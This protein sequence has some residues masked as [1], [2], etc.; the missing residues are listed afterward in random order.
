MATEAH[1]FIGIAVFDSGCSSVFDCDVQQ[2][3]F[4]HQ[5]PSEKVYSA[6]SAA[7]MSS[8]SFAS[9][10]LRCGGFPR[11]LVIPGMPLTS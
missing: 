7:A 6:V 11:D 4:R 2:N 8:W 3:H 9:F 1:I 5:W 10:V